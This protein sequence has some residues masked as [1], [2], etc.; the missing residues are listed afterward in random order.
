[1]TLL[2]SFWAGAAFWFLL[3]V[4]RRPPEGI[5]D[6][7]YAVAQ[8]LILAA[9]ALR[10]TRL[11]IELDEDGVT[12]FNFFSTM[13]ISWTEIVDVRATY[14]GLAIALAD[15]R[16]LTATAVPRPDVSWR[17]KADDVAD[18]LRFEALRRRG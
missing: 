13:R 14:F 11:R 1:M 17:T 2:F 9:S 4:L 8:G 12:A 7:Y 6:R 3:E 18:Y 16:T 15:G 10:A 5:L